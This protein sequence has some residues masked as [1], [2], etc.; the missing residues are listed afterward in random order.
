MREIKFRGKGKDGRW[1]YGDLVQTKPYADGHVLCWIKEV[2]I[3]GL[4]IDSTP[5]YL[6]HEVAPATVNQ[7]TGLRD[8]NGV[9]IYEG[10]ILRSPYGY[11]DEPWLYYEVK[12][13]LSSD[14]RWGFYLDRYSAASTKEA[15]ESMEVCGT[16][17][18]QKPEEGR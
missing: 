5:T 13:G 12:F 9:E 10:D 7:F 3:L 6:F 16:I 18:D 4:G 1:W 17:H 2:D 14:V 11:D 15:F 8:K